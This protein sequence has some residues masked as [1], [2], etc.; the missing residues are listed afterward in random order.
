VLFSGLVFRASQPSHES[1]LLAPPTAV[2]AVTSAA[3]AEVVVRLD[4]D[5]F[6]Q[7][8]TRALSWAGTGNQTDAPNGDLIYIDRY[9]YIY[10]YIER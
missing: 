8:Y 5:S 10:I 7:F 6:G 4:E 1:S 3:L 2:E 9:V